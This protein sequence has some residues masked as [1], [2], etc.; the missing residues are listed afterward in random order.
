M[1]GAG[2]MA[3]LEWDAKGSL[4]GFLSLTTETTKERERSKLRS[5]VGPAVP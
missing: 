1:L 5:S 3:H 4:R 2:A